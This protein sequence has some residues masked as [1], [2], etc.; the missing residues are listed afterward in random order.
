MGGL[1]FQIFQLHP[2]VVNVH[3]LANG[4]RIDGGIVGGPHGPGNEP[5]PA[6]LP[7]ILKEALIGN[8]RMLRRGVMKQ[9]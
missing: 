4:A 8:H 7:A 6:G 9:L 3:K 5:V 2:G 1:S